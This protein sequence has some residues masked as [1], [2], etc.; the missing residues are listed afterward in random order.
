MRKEKHII[1]DTVKFVGRETEKREDGCHYFT[2]NQH[3]YFGQK[4]KVVETFQYL[5]FNRAVGHYK[6]WYQPGYKVVF[7]DGHIL[8]EIETD[9][10]KV[11]SKK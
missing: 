7:E 9:L 5:E 10:H 8:Y 3:P 6:S 11:R 1:G 4:C 2:G